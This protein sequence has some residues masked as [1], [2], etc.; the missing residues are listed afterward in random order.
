V[1]GLGQFG[2]ELTGGSADQRVR[3]IR[4]PAAETSIFSE[5]IKSGRSKVGCFSD[6]AWDA[7]LVK[8][9]GGR[10]PGEFFLV[11]L[12]C[13]GRVAAVLYGDNLPEGKPLPSLTGLE[14]FLHQA[15]LA[16]E[17]AL[18]ERRLTELEGEKAKGR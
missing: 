1:R 18:L 2:I 6:S 4:L 8:E 16:M 9:L 13:N 7:Y 5:V 14:I 17:K 3:H 11:P 15:G 12:V 10:E